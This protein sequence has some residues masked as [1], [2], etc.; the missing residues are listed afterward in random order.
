M[1]IAWGV[2]SLGFAQTHGVVQ[3]KKSGPEVS[4]AWV[5]GLPLG[6]LGSRGLRLELPPGPHEVWLAFD[7]QAMITACH[8]LVDAS[9]GVEQVVHLKSSRVR[10]AGLRPGLPNGPT[11]WRG[12]FVH[13]DVHW[14]SSLWLTVNNGPMHKLPYGPFSLNLAPGPQKITLL[15]GYRYDSVLDQH[16]L[17]LNQGRSVSM[18]C[19]KAGCA[20]NWQASVAVEG[21]EEAPD[22]VLK[23]DTP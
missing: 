14:S 16:H 5:D 19:T 21:L 10:C 9:P 4:Y 2:P 12:S 11:A 7:P 3:L 13:V 22:L 17:S 1:L 15:D 6:A 18:R 23:T 8:G 20:G